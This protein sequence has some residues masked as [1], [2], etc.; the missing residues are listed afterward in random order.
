VA[1]DV[2]VVALPPGSQFNDFTPVWYARRLV[3]R[4][5]HGK[6]TR[7]ALAPRLERFGLADAPIVIAKGARWPGS[8]GYEPLPAK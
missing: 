3:L 7:E 2:A 1:T 8:E 6:E 5:E 4:L